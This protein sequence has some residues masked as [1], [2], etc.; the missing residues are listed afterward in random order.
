M[1]IKSRKDSVVLAFDITSF[2]D[3]LDHSHLHKMWCKVIDKERLPND[4]F[5]VYKSVTTYSTVEKALLEIEFGLAEKKENNIYLTRICTPLEFR[6]RVR[7]GNLIEAN[8]FKNKVKKSSR[9][10]EKCGIPQGSPISA[11]LSN[12]YMIDFDIRINAIAN[13]SGGLYRRYCDDIVLIVNPEDFLRIKDYVL[14]TIVEY[15]LDINDSKRD[16]TYFKTLEPGILKSYDSCNLS[17]EKN[18][19]YLGFE[20]NGKNAYIRSSSLSKYYRRMTARIRENLKAAY[21]G[22][23]I[24]TKIF[25]K[26]L[27]NRYTNKGERNFITYAERAFKHME[28][29]S[30]YKQVKNSTNKVKKKLN[31]KN[32]TFIDKR[33]KIMK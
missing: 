17:K 22:N 11:C 25:R 8:P 1:Y 14:N 33:P 32:D 5:N 13:E 12:I 16:I 19:Q 10:N 31:K 7:N 9:Y 20:F 15:Q 18:M 2:F 6:E 4:H 27:Y 28:S 26:K 3:G 21:G 30:I 24:G 23:S 29:K